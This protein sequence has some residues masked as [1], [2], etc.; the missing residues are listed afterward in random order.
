MS[1]LLIKQ[2][3]VYFQRALDQI[4]L[5]GGRFIQNINL[6]YTRLNLYGYEP[7]LL[8]SYEQIFSGTN[9]TLKN[10][11]LDFYKV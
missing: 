9:T 6:N 11:M 3:F 5:E 10:D 1:K 2:S 4:Y 7:E 8:G